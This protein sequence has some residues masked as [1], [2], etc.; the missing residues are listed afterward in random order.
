MAS[1]FST[2]T[3]KCLQKRNNLESKHF[4][5]SNNI[6][7]P[8]IL[9]P[10]QYTLEEKTRKTYL[11]LDGNGRV[12]LYIVNIAYHM[13]IGYAEALTSKQSILPIIS[14]LVLSSSVCFRETKLFVN[15]IVTKNHDLMSKQLET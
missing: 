13:I 9:S 11:K 15:T 6:Q 5:I 4:I 2:Q 14:R 1:L 3:L 7:F 12:L 10:L 8:H